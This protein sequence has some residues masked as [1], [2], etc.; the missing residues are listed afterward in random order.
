MK[1]WRLKNMSTC[2]PEVANGGTCAQIN[3][4]CMWERLKREKRQRW[5]HSSWMSTA[6]L[7]L[8]LNNLQLKLPGSRPPDV[9]AIKSGPH[10]KHIKGTFCCILDT[11]TWFASQQQGAT[12][13]TFFPF[14]L[15]QHTLRFWMSTKKKK[16]RH[17]LPSICASWFHSQSPTA[18]NAGQCFTIFQELQTTRRHK[19]CCLCIHTPVKQ[20]M[21]THVVKPQ[22]MYEKH[23][24]HGALLSVETHNLERAR[25]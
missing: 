25:K 3:N 16:E 7:V 17:S 13:W 10:S 21:R 9:S 19:Q 11:H 5:T 15:L 4:G 14:T 23:R 24:Y 18:P 2:E 6:E 12:L 8:T 20:N 1:K 22:E